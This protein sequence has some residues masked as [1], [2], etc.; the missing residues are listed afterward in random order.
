MLITVADQ[1]GGIP[2]SI[3]DR[4]FDPF[5]TTKPA[6]KGTGLGLSISFASVTEMGGKIRVRNENG[7]AVFE[8]ELPIDGIDRAHDDAAKRHAA[9]VA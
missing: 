5:L 2:P 8:I 4:V 9:P 3:I 6:S 1:A 7:G